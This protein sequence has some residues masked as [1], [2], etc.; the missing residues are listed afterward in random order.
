MLRYLRPTRGIRLI[1]VDAICINQND[2]V[3]RG[4]QVAKMGQIYSQCS[5]V[6]VWLGSDLVLQ[7]AG[8]YPRRYRLSELGHSVSP[9]L[10]SQDEGQGSPQHILDITSLL[11]RRYFSRVWVIRKFWGRSH[12]LFRIVPRSSPGTISSPKTILIKQMLTPPSP[13][14]AHSGAPN[15]TSH[16]KYDL[17][18]RCCYVEVSGKRDGFVITADNSPLVRALGTR[19]TTSGR[20]P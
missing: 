10:P 19:V 15:H 12:F 3:E 14:R 1:W 18:G 5:Q 13:R 16:R 11:E 17:L 6:V 9:R 2:T 20:S 8:V 7:K 4:S